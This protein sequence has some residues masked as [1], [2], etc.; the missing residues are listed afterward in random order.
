MKFIYLVSPVSL[1]NSIRQYLMSVGG[2]L[3]LG[4]IVTA[5]LLCKITPKVR[6]DSHCVVGCHWP[7]LFY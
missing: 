6:S 1:G 5:V 2:Q 3:P 4:N 7:P